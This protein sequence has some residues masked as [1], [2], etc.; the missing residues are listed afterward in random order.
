M[1]DI[2]QPHLCKVFLGFFRVASLEDLQ[3]GTFTS[4][5]RL[6]IGNQHIKSTIDFTG[7]MPERA[8][9]REKTYLLELVCVLCFG[10]LLACSL[11]LL[12][13]VPVPIEEKVNEG[14]YGNRGEQGSAG[15]L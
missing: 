9:V 8:G 1:V 10:V 15:D 3:N 2:V 14:I 5:A 4:R 7:A 12:P 11:D 6:K 13:C